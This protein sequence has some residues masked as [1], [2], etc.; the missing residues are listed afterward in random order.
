MSSFIWFFGIFFFFK[1][2]WVERAASL[3]DK[4]KIEL[5]IEEKW[6]YVL[7]LRVTI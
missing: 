2:V 4:I 7:K 3:S 1:L 6:N 5:L